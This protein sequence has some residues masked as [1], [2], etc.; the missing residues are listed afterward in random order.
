MRYLFVIMLILSLSVP[1][2]A[3]PFMSPDEVPE[4]AN[5][6]KTVLVKGLSHPWG[7]ARLPEG[8]ILI[9]ERP[10]RVQLYQGGEVKSVPGAP[11]NFAEGQGG[12]LDIALH[13]DFA[14]NRLVYFSMSIGT[15]KANRTAL[16]RARFD[17]ERFTDVQELFRVTQTKPDTQHFGSRLVWLPDGTLLMTIGDGGNPPVKVDGKLSRKYAQDLRSHLGKILRFNDDGSPVGS[18]AFAEEGG[19][20]ELYSAGHRNIQGLAHDPIRG[21]VWASEHGALGGDELNRIEPGG[22]YGWPLATFSKEYL[23][24]RE[25]SEHTSLPG[26]VDPSL[27]WLEGIAPSGLCLYTGDAFPQWK[28]DL[29]A[30]GLRGK[31]IRLVELDRAGNVTG[32]KRIE[33]NE[34]VR[35]ISQGPNGLI[36]VLTDEDDGKLIRLSPGK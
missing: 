26:K 18:G 19:L 30:G 25:I 28:G 20:P 33:M 16:S 23:F 22:N 32:E 24:A 6:K 13:P 2:G 27:V 34:R 7:M 3:A 5:V 11:E 15:E 1:A 36:Y 35:E 8:G 17:G 4:I 12:L 21:T 29:L 9:T 31:T 14:S 10:G